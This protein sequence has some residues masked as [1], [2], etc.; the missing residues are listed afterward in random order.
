MKLAKEFDSLVDQL[1]SVNQI[2]LLG[3]QFILYCNFDFSLETFAVSYILVVVLTIKKFLCYRQLFKTKLSGK[4]TLF[5]LILS[6]ICGVVN[7]KFCE[8]HHSLS[9]S[10]DFV[11]DRNFL[12][13]V[14]LSK[15]LL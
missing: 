10:K 6:Q 4:L 1:S 7:Q 11:A 9:F 15:F 8:D 14:H 2:V 5:L 13:V 12:S 3:D